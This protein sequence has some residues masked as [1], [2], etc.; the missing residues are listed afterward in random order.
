M[1]IKTIF[2]DRDG[3]INKEIGYLNKIDEFEFIYGIFDACL[4][5]QSLSYKIKFIYFVKVVH[6]FIYNSITIKKNS[7]YSHKLR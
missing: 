1:A 2:I 4:Y 6:F 7:F 5:F 3:V